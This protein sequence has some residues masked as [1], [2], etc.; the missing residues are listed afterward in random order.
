MAFQYRPCLSR[1]GIVSKVVTVGVF[2]RKDV[3]LYKVFWRWWRS[4][5][6][7][8]VWHG[9]DPVYRGAPLPYDI[10]EAMLRIVLVFS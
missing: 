6:P 3:G 4:D 8:I 2:Y 9:D 10:D 5:I 1:C 7:C